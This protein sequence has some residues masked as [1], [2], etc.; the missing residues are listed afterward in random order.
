MSKGMFKPA[1]T[2]LIICCIALMGCYIYLNLAKWRDRGVIVSDSI[3]YYAYLPATFM[4]H[5]LSLDFRDK[6][7]CPS[8]VALWPEKAPNGKKVIKTSMGMAIFYAPLFFLARCYAFVSQEQMSGYSTHDHLLV[9]FTAILYVFLG[10]LVLRR[11][12]IRYFSERLTCSVILILSLGTN[13]FYYFTVDTMSAHAVGFFLIN[14][15]VYYTIR[16]HEAQ[17][18]KYAILLGLCLG[19]LT[20]V[21]PTN[22]LAAF[23]FILFQVYNRDTLFAKFSLLKKNAGMLCLIPLLT[24]LVFLPQ[25][26]YWKMQTGRYFFNS[27]V[28]EVF[29]FSKPHIIEGLVGFRKGWLIYTPLMM[30]FF[31]GIFFMRQQLRDWFIPCGIFFIII[32]WVMFSWWCWWYGGS[33]GARVYVDFYGLFALAIATFIQVVYAKG[34]TF[35]KKS[36]FVFCSVC[37]LLNIMQSNQAKSNIIHYDSMT[38]A[39]YC[40]D[41]FWFGTELDH[42]ANLLQHPDYEKAKRCGEE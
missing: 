16:W 34:V 20:L 40:T 9:G 3:S 2:K 18:I 27:Y 25:L 10:L 37:I 11:I 38:W 15:F 26:L 30:L 32:T 13:L 21:R 29:F 36:L 4:Y 17:K 6:P 39:K 1:W 31:A 23:L 5:D 7:T 41:F 35:W 22:I 12:L 42:N 19:F 14:V 33:F 8:D 24:I 28:G